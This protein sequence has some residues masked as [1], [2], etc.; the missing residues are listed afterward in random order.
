V[1]QR[2]EPQAPLAQPRLLHQLLVAAS[3]VPGSLPAPLHCCCLLPGCRLCCRTRRTALCRGCPRWWLLARLTACGWQQ[4]KLACSRP[5]VCCHSKT[6]TRTAT[7]MAVP[8]VHVILSAAGNRQAVAAGARTPCRHSHLLQLVKPRPG[9][10]NAACSTTHCGLLSLCR[11]GNTSAPH[12]PS[13][14]PAA[15]SHH[16]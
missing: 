8:R 11:R 9:L 7:Y 1:L 6:C 3:L 12:P 15:D 14:S 16:R 5:A 4:S 10:G 2:V 13:V